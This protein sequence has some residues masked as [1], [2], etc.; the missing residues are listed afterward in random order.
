MKTAL[1]TSSSDENTPAD[2]QSDSD[3]IEEVKGIAKNI[4]KLVQN[5][6][7]EKKFGVDFAN[8]KARLN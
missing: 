6:K 4:S 2:D 8:I 1:N 7:D 5:R 3:K